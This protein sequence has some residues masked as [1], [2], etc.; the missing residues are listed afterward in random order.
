MIVLKS[1]INHD[2]PW[3]KQL[4]SAKKLIGLL[5]PT[6]A[7]CFALSNASV[8]EFGEVAYCDVDDD[9]QE[10]RRYP[11]ILLKREDSRRSGVGA[12]RLAREGSGVGSQRA[13]LPKQPIQLS[14]IAKPKIC[15]WRLTAVAPLSPCN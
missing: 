5:L 15:S 2:R 14:K 12:L 11:R 13:L 1:V 3:Y 7:L 8:V 10:S 6:G 9:Q 4:H